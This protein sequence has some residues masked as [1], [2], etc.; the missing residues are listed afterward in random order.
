MT[1]FIFRTSAISFVNLSIVNSDKSVFCANSFKDISLLLIILTSY[2]SLKVSNFCKHSLEVSF[3]H[4]PSTVTNLCT[5]IFLFLNCFST[6]FHLS[7]LLYKDIT[8]ILSKNLLIKGLERFFHI[9]ITK[10]KKILTIMKITK[11]NI[12]I[13]LLSKLCLS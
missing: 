8:K 2:I 1:L 9:Y 10:E 4:L 5:S 6:L 13:L 12:Y 11:Y 3:L 7:K